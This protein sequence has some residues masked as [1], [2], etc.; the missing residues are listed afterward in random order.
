MWQDGFT[1][2]PPWHPKIFTSTSDAGATP[3]PPWR[4][5]AAAD[6]RT[7][8]VKGAA[9]IAWPVTMSRPSISIRSREIVEKRSQACQRS[10]ASCWAGEFP[11]VAQPVEAAI[12][13]T[14]PNA[15]ARMM[16]PLLSR[17]REKDG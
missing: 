1:W 5:C 4:A 17:S 11:M 12:T 3:P 2:A 7:H 16:S 8:A 10:H 14:K 9:S 13:R 6:S 15:D